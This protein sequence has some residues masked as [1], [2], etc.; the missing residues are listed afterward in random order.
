MRN[1]LKTRVLPCA[2]VLFFSLSAHAE[3]FRVADIRIEGLQRISAGTVFT[4]LPVAAG[5]QFD[6]ANSAQAI[7]A[8]YKSNLFSQVR[9]ARDGN[10][11]VVQ[12]EEFPVIAE[13]NLKGN[14]D[15]K[16]EDLQKALSAA[17][18][19]EGQAY[20]P[21]MLQQLVQE[22]TEQYQARSKYAVKIEPKVR[23][24]PRGRVAID[25]DISEG[26][27][28]RI[29]QIDIVGNKIYSDKQLVSLFDTSTPRW[30]S[31]LTKS[32]QYDRDKLQADIDRLESFYRDRGFMDFAVTS[33]QV[34]LSPDR[35]WI[36]LTVNMDEGKV[37]R[38]KGYQLQGDL[39]VPRTE[40]ESLITFKPGDRY[41]RSE[42]RKS[43]DALRTRL[44]DEGYA[45]AQ[46]HVVPN[47][48]T[49]SGEVSFD[50][51]V[52][53]GIKTYVRQIGFTGNTKTYDRVL[54][55]ELRQQEASLYSGSDVARSEERLRRLPQVETLEQAI[56]PV[57]GTPDQVDLEYKITE[58]ST[59]SIQG[60]VGYGQSSGALFNL[61]YNDNNF[62]GTG[63]SLGINFGK[64]SSEQRYGFDF[65]DP[66]FTADGVS[67]N[68]AFDY[69][70]TN[71]RKERL[72]DWAAD[73]LDATITFGY[74]LT[75]YQSVYFG[76][77]F[78]TLKIN[79]GDN[80]ASEITDY[81]NK[82]GRRYKEGVVTLAWNKDTQDNTY[83]P[84]KG[85]LNKISGEITLPGSDDTYYK[86]GY[87][88]RTY[89]PLNDDKSLIL[90]LRGDIAY[91]GGYGKTDDLPFYRHYYAGGLT[92][93]RGFE[94][95]SL[96]PRYSNGDT[97]GG[98]FR[99]V[100]GVELMTPWKINEKS[101]NVRV[102][103]FIDF[104]NVYSKPKDFDLGEFR[105]SGGL[106]VQWMSPLGPLNLSYA[107]PI[108]KKDGDEKEAFQFSFGMGF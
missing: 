16:S 96:G 32:D 89:F 80:V 94:H 69:S 37:Y 14:R 45:Q 5:Q 86:I 25:L 35:K 51:L 99:T 71:Y 90:G 61:E 82:K 60:G 13:V 29:K 87:R 43:T 93:V 27:S 46:V 20:N 42:V 59:S 36:Y 84:T 95:S 15:L 88:N 64:S 34:S 10:V 30:N 85:S 54:R 44:A 3:S 41:N 75:E 2:A 76:G 26:R 105:Y 73:T 92:T 24:L 98:D 55:R 17:G 57:P 56:H 104:G 18:I 70:K 33:T 77:G 52:T 63:N 72:S 74:P 19:S 81:L 106:F 22:L 48:D 47:A 62:L 28:S 9:L 49:L 31:W 68:Y 8:L 83:L 91:G 78:R 101:N 4:Y 12:V 7:D 53:P 58:R 67:I 38:V 23:Q 97:S 21:Q 79:T 50:I 100:G 103:T 108:K 6:M 102:G 66:Y 107:V 1:T 11:L 40:L 39:I 65:T